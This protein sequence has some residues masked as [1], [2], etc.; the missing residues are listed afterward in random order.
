MKAFKLFTKICAVIFTLF[1]GIVMI[2][3][4]ILEDNADAVNDALNIQTEQ[5]VA[6]DASDQDSY[7]Y[8]S[9]FTS[10][11]G[12]R[13]NGMAYCEAVMAEGATLLK[14]DGALPL[15]E[16][17]KVS[18]FSTSSVNHFAVGT[19]SS[20]AAGASSGEIDFKT[21]FEDAGLGVNEELWDWYESNF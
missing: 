2:G 20:N 11:S 1:F 12:V 5:Y 15:A 18:L 17:A 10:V 21:A 16:G 3:G 4:S 13:A 8:K 6:G 14:N 19:G 9:A 7:Y